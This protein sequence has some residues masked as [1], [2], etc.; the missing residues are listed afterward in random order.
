M[1][2]VL[3]KQNEYVGF[4]GRIVLAG[5]SS[6]ADNGGD[7]SLDVRKPLL[8]A[9]GCVTSRVTTGKG[10]VTLPLAGQLGRQ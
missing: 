7:L 10:E 6:V 2:R 5:M 1:H 4:I 3:R 9:Q 8:P